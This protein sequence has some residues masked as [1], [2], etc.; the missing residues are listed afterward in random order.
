MTAICVLC[1]C[2]I[3][4]INGVIWRINRNKW[5]YICDISACR[6]VAC[7]VAGEGVF[8]ILGDDIKAD[9]RGLGGFD[10]FISD[11]PELGTGAEEVEEEGHHQGKDSRGDEDLEEGEGGTHASGRWLGSLPKAARRVT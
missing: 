9:A 6:G 11:F 7:H 3:G 10:F 1:I 5:G 4:K 2:V 8:E